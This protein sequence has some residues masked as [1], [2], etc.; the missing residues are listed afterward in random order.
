[1][2]RGSDRLS[3]HRDDE[4]KHELQGLLRSGHPTRVEEW[5]D[6]EPG[7]DDDLE[8]A[9]GPVTPGRSGVSLEAV[10]LEL[11][12]VL[13][14]GPFPATAGELAGALRGGH[15]PDTFVEAVEALPREQR[16]ANVQQLAEA[17]TDGRSGGDG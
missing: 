12:R 7:A 15:A 16:Y 13:G 2:Q 6:P 4:M 11:A 10:R 1:M 9:G 3:V 17:L 5:H 8:V 14:R